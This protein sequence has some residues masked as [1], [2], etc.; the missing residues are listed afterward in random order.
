MKGPLTLTLV[1]FLACCGNNIPDAQ[2][3][4]EETWD[5]F[6][7]MDDWQQDAISCNVII[8][9]GYENYPDP[10]KL[11]EFKQYF[12]D[13]IANAGIPKDKSITEWTDEESDRWLKSIEE[14]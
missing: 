3:V 1:I 11:E 7:Y 12:F 6:E 8:E 5:N 4:Y 14:S 9:R 2:E 13:H 10:N